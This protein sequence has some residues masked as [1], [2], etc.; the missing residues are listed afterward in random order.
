[1]VVRQCHF[2]DDSSG[3]EQ[4]AIALEWVGG[5]HTANNDHLYDHGARSNRIRIDIPDGEHPASG[6]KVEG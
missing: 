2:G 6:G 4:R 3:S 5:R 1:M